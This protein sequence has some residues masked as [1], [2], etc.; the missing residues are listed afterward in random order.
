[1]I[2]GLTSAAGT[3]GSGFVF[4]AA[5]FLTMSLVGVGAAIVLLAHTTISRRPALAPQTA[6]GD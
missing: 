6:P 3:L 1:M 4:A 2:V 5:G